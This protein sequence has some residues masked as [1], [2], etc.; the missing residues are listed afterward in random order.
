MNPYAHPRET[1]VGTERP[2]IQHI[3][4]NPKQRRN[5]AER[6][7]DKEGVIAERRAIKKAARRHLK[8]QLFSELDDE[9]VS[10]KSRM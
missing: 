8:E 7:A 3:A 2:K 6:H 10:P 1:K 9:V 4:E 5:R